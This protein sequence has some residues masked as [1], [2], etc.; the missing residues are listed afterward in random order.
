M[1]AAERLKNLMLKRNEPQ[2]SQKQTKSVT[3]SQIAIRNNL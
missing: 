2:P 3:I 1:Y